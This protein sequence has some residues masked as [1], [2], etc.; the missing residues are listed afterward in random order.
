MRLTGI[1]AL[2]CGLALVLALQD[3]LL[4]AVRLPLAAPDLLL[5]VVAAVAF[6]RGRGPACWSASC[7]AWP[8]T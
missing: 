6:V 8:P 1:L 5:A 4:S 2:L 3:L 7:W